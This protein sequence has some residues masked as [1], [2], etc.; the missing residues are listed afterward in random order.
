M[1]KGVH[2]VVKKSFS[3]TASAFIVLVISGFVSLQPI[4][5]S[6]S[7]A[8]ASDAGLPVCS[9]ITMTPLNR[10]ET[11]PVP[12]LL[13]GVADSGT[14]D[15][16][17][18][19]SQPDQA[20][21]D[22]AT[23]TRFA[24]EGKQVHGWVWNTNLGYMS[25][26]CENG[27]NNTSACGDI[28][29]GA[30]LKPAVDGLN[31][32]SVFG[33][34]WGDAMGWVSMGCSEGNN[35]GTA[36]GGVDYGVKAAINDGVASEYCVGSGE[37]GT[38]N[39]GDLYGYAWSD[40]VGWVNFCGAH[41][42]DFNN[43][44]AIGDFRAEVTFG[45]STSTVY[46]NGR[47]S[48]DI[49]VKVYET[50]NGVETLM[51]P[52]N[53]RIEV[54]TTETN[55][56]RN[57]QVS[58]C[59]EAGC[60]YTAVT[61]G[62]FAWV[63]PAN[64][65]TLRAHRGAY[66][67]RITSTA[68]TSL[69]DT[70]SLTGMSVKIY[71][72][73]GAP[74]EAPLHTIELNPAAITHTFEFNAPVEVSS[75]VTVS[76]DGNEVPVTSLHARAGTSQHLRLR[77]TQ[78]TRDGAAL[79]LGLPN[80]GAISIHSQLYDCSNEYRFLFDDNGNGVIKTAGA[81]PNAELVVEDF[82]LTEEAAANPGVPLAFPKNVS[83]N[84]AQRL[85]GIN[86]NN[87]LPGDVFTVTL[88]DSAANNGN[89]YVHSVLADGVA[90]VATEMSNAVGLQTI[91]EYINPAGTVIRYLSK[92][93]KNGSIINQ[94]A[95]VTGNVRLDILDKKGIPADGRIDASIGE[96]AQSK[97]EPFYRAI[98]AAVGTTQPQAFVNYGDNRPNT[99]KL[100]TQ[101]FN[102]STGILYFK[103][104]TVG[105]GVDE[106]A[107]CKI[108][109]DDAAGDITLAKDVT[110]VSEGCDVYIDQ[111]IYHG[112]NSIGRLGVIALED[113]SMPGP[114]RGGNVYVC[115][116]V[117][118]V[119]ANF[120]LDNSLFSYASGGD[121]E[122]GNTYKDTNIQLGG[123]LPRTATPEV[124]R[125]QLTILGSLISNNT[126]GGSTQTPPR[127]GDGTKATTPAQIAASKYYDLNFMRYASTQSIQIRQGGPRGALV[128]RT[129]W[130]QNVK[131]SK[132]ILATALP[133]FNP[134][135]PPLPDSPE[136]CVTARN[137]P[138][139]KG[140]FNII[141]RAPTSKQPVFN[142]L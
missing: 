3:L 22:N 91:I 51:A 111:N 47:D 54:E 138:E 90:N 124:L 117:T 80:A 141:Y 8:N 110:L 96:R 13:G 55:T 30:V 97:R 5:D 132:N 89:V 130:A 46:A 137:N 10:A 53:Y 83:V 23:T 34:S 123:D 6:A 140:I 133:N 65:F 38:L 42:N 107:P 93:T 109:L 33:F 100:G 82:D 67:S 118:D 121:G 105:E 2:R 72:L 15:F 79:N 139:D 12:A 14:L 104:T 37:G 88:A 131:L 84:G 28:D 128:Q 69:S 115:S 87:A 19:L 45:T 126:Y 66:V 76:E 35:L 49:I 27:L 40:S 63:D 20:C 62:P 112:A 64:R 29:Y 18:V 119:E 56:V 11:D 41:I 135:N 74:G 103:H 113:F 26:A 58:V 73:Q 52:E 61:K 134:A 120:V 122:C 43:A 78:Q 32:S 142:L 50:Q 99:R 4:T 94:A 60:S 125:H 25:M 39:K 116:R 70:L 108:I 92:A 127:L 59:P 44:A 86:P 81:E 1:H 31:D 7:T 17:D 57:D 136:A 36:C 98:Q 101:D 106:S 85:C 48:H 129:C 16:G 9:D 68:P 114:R 71:S 24:Q 102:A 21:V 75:I 95:N 77:S